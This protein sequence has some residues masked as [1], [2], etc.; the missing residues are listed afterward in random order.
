MLS[1]VSPTAGFCLHPLGFGASALQFL[2]FDLLL[3][4]GVGE[5]ISEI[6]LAHEQRSQ[7]QALI[8]H[9]LTNGIEDC[10]THL[11]ASL[12]VDSLRFELGDNI[13][14]FGSYGRSD[15]IGLVTILPVEVNL[16]DILPSNAIENGD[17]QLHFLPIVRQ[18]F[19]G[20]V[21]L[22]TPF[23]A[24]ARHG[25]FAL[26]GRIDDV[27]LQARDDDRGARR[28]R[29][30]LQLTSQNI[31]DDGRPRR[32]YDQYAGTDDEKHNAA[33]KTEQRQQHAAPRR[34]TLRCQG[35]GEGNA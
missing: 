4:D 31:D 13:T 11:F 3:F 2:V 21:A 12:A 26:V 19:H 29:R 15:E 9:F 33:S 5:C 30:I 10:L 14:G 28:P 20:V 22:Q 27:F 18:R 7:C 34:A 17:I 6:D 16:I 23:T 25:V 1:S 8:L 24:D 32:L 35:E